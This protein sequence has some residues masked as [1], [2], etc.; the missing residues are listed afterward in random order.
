MNYQQ[1]RD[2]ALQCS[3]EHHLHDAEE[4]AKEKTPYE[5]LETISSGGEFIPM[6]PYEFYDAE[7]VVNSIEDMRG[8]NVW[9]FMQVLKQINGAEWVINF[10][11]GA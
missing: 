2:F 3:L 10:K 4:L 11:A 9:Q 7:S 6:E 8:V 5:I 1:L